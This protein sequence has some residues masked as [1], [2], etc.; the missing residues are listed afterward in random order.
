[1][2]QLLTNKNV[3]ITVPT[4]VSDLTN[5]SGFIKDIPL[6]YVTESELQAKGYL[7]STSI[8]R[9]ELVEE[10]PTTQEYGVLYI[11]RGE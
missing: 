9:I 2:E 5:D 8:T 4:K 6:E 11:V 3:D 1:M 10:L 7:T